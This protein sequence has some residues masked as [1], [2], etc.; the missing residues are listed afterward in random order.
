MAHRIK[1]YEKMIRGDHVCEQD[2][3]EK[4][5]MDKIRFN[6][7]EHYK[8]R[9]FVNSLNHLKKGT[10]KEKCLDITTHYRL[11]KNDESHYVVS[12]LSDDE[13]V[14]LKNCI[15]ECIQ[16]ECTGIIDQKEFIPTGMHCYYHYY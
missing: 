5:T 15:V 8:Q 11:F 1:K 7:L 9:I 3:Y 6:E 16:K 4:E 12:E 10:L 14:E 13:K 2:S